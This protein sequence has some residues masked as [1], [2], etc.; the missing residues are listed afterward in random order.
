MS[1]F[2]DELWLCGTLTDDHDTDETKGSEMAEEPDRWHAPAPGPLYWDFK[3]LRCDGLV[4]DHPGFIRRLI[5]QWR[6][7]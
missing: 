3:C 4:R 7:R 1:T 5:H 6:N 2:L